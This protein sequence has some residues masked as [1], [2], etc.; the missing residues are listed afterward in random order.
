MP[1]AP[2]D[3]VLLAEAA[4]LYAVTPGAFTA[5]RDARSR[6]LRSQDAALAAAVKRLRKPTTAAWVVNLLVR[7]EP[8]QVAEILAVGRALREARQGMAGEELRG[9]TRQRRQLTAAVTGRARRHA[10]E[11]GQSVTRAV[12]DQVEATLTA[13]MLDAGCAAAVRSG[14]LVA[15]LAATGMEE[16]DAAAAVA[17]PGALGF[18]VT[19]R[20]DA[21]VDAADPRGPPTLH[22]VPDPDADA[23][24]RTEADVRLAAAQAAVSEA[25]AGAEGAHGAVAELQ[26]RSMQLAAEVDELR[27]RIDEIEAQAEAVDEELA[28]AE[29]ADERARAALREATRERD[30][31][32]R[33]RSSLD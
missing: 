14:L 11:A 21:A 28:G 1:D 20:M 29:Q 27:R 19:P 25:R 12:A 15:A 6:K 18:V 13:A 31:A 2:D 7:S 32:Q 26:A 17:L 4:A 33:A 3:A 16:V 24:A 10:G 23:K 30:G 8:E 22:V 5:T 9:L